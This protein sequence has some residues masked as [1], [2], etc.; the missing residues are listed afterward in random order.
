MRFIDPFIHP[1]IFKYQLIPALNFSMSAGKSL[2]S[3]WVKAPWTKGEF[4]T[5]PQK[6]MNIIIHS[7]IHTHWKASF[8]V[9]VGLWGWRWRSREKPCRHMQAN[10]RPRHFKS[11]PQPCA[12]EVGLLTPQPD[13][14]QDS[15]CPKEGIANTV[16]EDT[17]LSSSFLLNNLF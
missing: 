11:N 15:K 14:F 1:S 2:S 13:R 10:K 6:K 3:H 9:V 4:I 7:H 5:G 16:I 17:F 12:F 8:Q